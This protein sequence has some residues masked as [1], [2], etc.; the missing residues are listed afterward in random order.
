MPRITL[1]WQLGELDRHSLSRSLAALAGTL[2]AAGLGRIYDR[3]LVDE[4]R[5]WREATG[6]S[7]H[8]GTLR[9]ARDPRRGVV[10]AHCRVHGVSNLY[11]AGSAVFP[12]TG[13]A[14]PTFTIVALA[15]RLAAHLK[16]EAR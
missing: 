16:R 12:T 3:T 6:G 4:D 11:V 2:G 15:L 7:H 13:Y 9:M 14:N 8:M 10:D 1:D 5:V